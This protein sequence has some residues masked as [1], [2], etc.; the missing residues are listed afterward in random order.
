M[1]NLGDLWDGLYPEERKRITTLLIDRV[2]VRSNG[3]DIEYR[4]EGFE[5]IID[6]LQL[7]LNANQQRRVA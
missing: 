6:D 3:I 7:K 2:V 5:K 4:A 1:K